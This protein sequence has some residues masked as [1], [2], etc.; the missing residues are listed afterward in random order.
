MNNPVHLP[1]GGT[2]AKAPAELLPGRTDGKAPHGF[3]PA[4]V[5]VPLCLLAALF[6]MSGFTGR[7]PWLHSDYNSYTLQ[8]LA[9]LEDRLDLG[10]DYPWLELAIVDGKYFVSFPPFPSFLLL[11]LAAVFGENTPDHLLSWL[12]TLAGGFF[13]VRLC[14]LAS[15]S[16]RHVT[17]WALFLYLGSGYMFIAQQGWVWFL[18][19]TLNF[20]LLLMAFTFALEGKGGWSLGVWACAVGCRPLSVL[21]LPVLFW[22]LH[23]AE[24]PRGLLPWVRR[25]WYWAIA[26]CLI[27]GVYM[28]LNLL[29]FGSVA[30]FGHTFLPE[31]QREAEGQFSLAYFRHN[32]PLLF[33]LPEV[34]A[35]TGILTFP[36]IDTSLF[37]LICPLFISMGLAWVRGLKKAWKPFR[38]PLL[39]LPLLACV[40]LF[41][42]CCH[43]TLGGFQ[44]GNRYLLDLLPALFTGLC[45]WL[46]GDDSSFHTWQT[47]LFVLGLVLNT[48]GTFVT[49]T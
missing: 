1:E 41:V 8:A 33:R 43:H 40:H 2:R 9:W 14:L 46:P 39:A 29:R 16:R 27:A 13:A 17:F 10:M 47:P 42:T 28:T 24:R 12:V 21:Y 7:W 15:G 32:F 22:L 4:Y 18:A 45:L 6:V 48:L 30:E 31:F 26:P 35:Q 37:F 44:F 36:R 11:P 19:Q 5:A 23:R 49:Y 25:R 20:T 38:F 34:N 3:H